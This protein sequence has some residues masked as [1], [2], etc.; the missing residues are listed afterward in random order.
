MTATLTS[1]AQVHRYFQ[2]WND[3]DPAAVVAAFV[4]GG[5]YVDPTVVG[6]PLSGQ[7]LAAH[8]QALFEGFPDLR[9]EV[10][11]LVTRPDGVT[12]A[13]WLM[14]GTNTGPLRGAPP[15]GQTVALPGVDFIATTEAGVRSVEGYFDRQAMAEQL[16]FQVLVQPYAMGPFRFGY[17][18]R[19]DAGHSTRPGAVSMTWIDTRSPA[20]AEQ[21]RAIT[22][23]L[24][25]ELRK[26]PGFLSWMGVGIGSRMFTITAWE[27]E[28]AARQVMRMPLHQ[29]A[30]RRFFTQDFGAAVHTG[31]WS[32]HHL[33]PLWLRCPSCR[34]VAD[35]TA[36]DT[37]DGGH[38]LPQRPAYW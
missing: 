21:V 19:T 26:V 31:V 33:N 7:A 6:P 3:R 37:C 8:A 15:S 20:E 5:T 25:A 35:A 1:Q 29:E 12:V 34:R 17:A 30:V 14:R 27:S 36:G 13:R 22:R 18:V 28:Q 23:P 10:P 4:E 24:A 11:E 9:F 2:A 32:A 16:G 38:R